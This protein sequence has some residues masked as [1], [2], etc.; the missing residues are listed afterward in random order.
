M[1]YVHPLLL[2]KTKGEIHRSSAVIDCGIVLR[3]RSDS[4]ANAICEHLANGGTLC[5]GKKLVTDNGLRHGLG[6]LFGE[7]VAVSRVHVQR[8]LRPT[9]P[10][11]GRR[12]RLWRNGP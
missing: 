10:E 5:D 3:M 6:G 1:W 2:S 4:G 12:G 11:Q 7:A 8:R 9:Y